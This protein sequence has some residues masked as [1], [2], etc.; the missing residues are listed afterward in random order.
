MTMQT[1]S[2]TWAPAESLTII[3]DLKEAFDRSDR[4]FH[5]AARLMSLMNI[6]STLHGKAV[7]DELGKNLIS[8]HSMGVTQ[9]ELPPEIVQRFPVGLVKRGVSDASSVSTAMGPASSAGASQSTSSD[10]LPVAAP[11]AAPKRRRR[12]AKV[13]EA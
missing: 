3:T 7:A 4:E 9:E 5:T 10:S 6:A 13:S 2:L 1:G 12:G 11:A 8:M